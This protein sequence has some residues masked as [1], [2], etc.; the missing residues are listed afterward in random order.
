MA[1]HGLLIGENYKMRILSIFM[2]VVTLVTCG[3]AAIVSG[4][5]FAAPIQSLHIRATPAD[6][7]LLTPT[8]TPARTST[9]TPLTVLEATRLTSGG[10]C[11]Y[12]SWSPGSKWVPFLDRPGPNEPAG[13]YAVPA[14]GGEITLVV[15]RVGV[16]SRDW[17]QVAYRQ[18]G[19]TLVERWADGMR[20]EIPN[21]GRTI[22]FSPSGRAVEW[23]VMSR[24]INFPDLRQRA[25]WLANFDGTQA[26]E[27]V[28]VNGGQ[29]V[30][31]V[32]N[33]EEII[34][35]GRLAPYGPAGIWQISVE[36]GA[37]RLLLEME[38]PRSPL[39]S[40]EGDWLAFTVA[41]DLDQELNGLWVMRTDG[42][43]VR[44]IEMYGSYR[45]RREGVLLVIPLD[46][47]DPG[48]SLWQIDIV[49]D[50]K[51]KLTD[52][53]VT[54]LPIANND[55]QPSPDG[56]QI[57]FLSAEDRNLWVLPLPEP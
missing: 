41:F 7:I 42:S 47:E 21:E 1:N 13:L 17:S 46:L 52:P 43:I 11:P 27:V 35:T 53:T 40:P 25:I 22:R 34:V 5:A 44:K 51:Y 20:W 56:T 19:Q 15:E 10:C 38:H 28:T 36:N 57:V 23:E 29:F 30:G 14:N 8:K 12:P 6:L 54:S 45:W 18:D 37:G 2:L 50:E 33:E 49:S 9:P 39:L 31:W 4:V 26:R 55:W 24:G 16:Y 3:I 48:S 32:G